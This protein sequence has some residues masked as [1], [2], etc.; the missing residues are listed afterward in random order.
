MAK[1]ATK[2]IYLERRGEEPGRYGNNHIVFDYTIN[3]TGE[4]LFTTTLPKECVEFLESKKIS[5]QSN[6]VGNKGYFSSDTLDG[7]VQRVQDV[8]DRYNS[9]KEVDRRMEIG[10]D[11]RLMCAYGKSVV[12]GTLH[13]N[14]EGGNREW[15]TG[16]IS[17][18]GHSGEFGIKFHVEV[19]DTYTMEYCDGTTK[20]VRKRHTANDSDPEYVKYLCGVVSG[21]DGYRGLDKASYVECSESVCNLFIGLYDSLFRLNEKIKDSLDPESLRLLAENGVKLLEK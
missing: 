9:A 15:V 3:V 10:Y 17:M 5:L 13:P 1:V 21:F 16:N 2:R 19:L 4:G 14:C 8:V 18:P 6:R 11:L 7:L 12:D 20:V